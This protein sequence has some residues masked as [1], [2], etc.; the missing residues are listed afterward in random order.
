MKELA[1]NEK[2]PEFT[3]DHEIA[4]LVLDFLFASQDASTASLVWIVT[5]LAN[6]MHPEVAKKCREEQRQIRPNG[7]KI[8][9]DNLNQMNY[10]LQVVKETL[11]F[12]PPATMVPMEVQ[13]QKGFEVNE[14]YT[15]PK[16]TLLIPD[17]WAACFEGFPEPEKFDPDRF[18]PERNEFAKHGTNWLPFGLGPH[19][20]MGRDYAQNHLMCFLAELVSHADWERTFT[21]DSDKVEYGPTIFPKDSLIHWT[22]LSQEQN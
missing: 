16:G 2:P 15:A 10:A 20:C 21:P 14:K 9:I 3:D 5:L 8:T 18:S 12:R 7:E 6:N 19:Y 17:I 11:R 1:D 13:D 4:C 22:K